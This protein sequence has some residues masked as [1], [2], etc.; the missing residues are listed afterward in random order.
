MRLINDGFTDGSWLS[1]QIFIGCGW[2]RLP[3]APLESSPAAGLDHAIPCF[4]DRP[5]VGTS[6]STA[7]QS[8][9]CRPSS[10]VLTHERGSRHSYSPTERFALIEGLPNLTTDGYTVARNCPS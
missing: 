8:D 3:F 7:L 2:I 10:T 4:T 9:W 1:A 5:A 6:N